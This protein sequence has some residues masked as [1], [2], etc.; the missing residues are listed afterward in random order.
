MPKF[1]LSCALRK[2]GNRAAAV[3]LPHTSTSGRRSRSTQ[4]SANDVSQ[5]Q[6][7]QALVQAAGYGGSVVHAGHRADFRRKAKVETAG[8][9]DNPTRD[10]HEDQAGAKRIHLARAC[11][12]KSNRLF[13]EPI[14]HPSQQHAC[15]QNEFA[16]Q[17]R[18]RTELDDGEK[19]KQRPMPQIKR[20]TDEPDPRHWLAREH[21]AA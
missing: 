6:I 12:T 9:D 10:R 19:H 14:G 17:Q 15:E 13:D 1:L 16:L 7:K 2:P 3:E 8:P 5:P 21:D 18:Q 4:L 20:I 11:L